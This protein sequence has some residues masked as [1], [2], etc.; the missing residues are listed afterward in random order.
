MNRGWDSVVCI[1]IVYP[2]LFDHA[3]SGE[4][5]ILETMSKILNDPFFT[6]IEV[7]WIKDDQV[8][9]NVRD[10]LKLS[11]ME[12]LYN[13]APPIRGMDVN[14]CS[15]DDGQRNQSVANF[16]KVIDE[17]YF[18]GAK[19]LHCVSGKDPGVDKRAEAKRNLIDSLQKLC[20]YAQEKATDYTLVVSLENS[21]RE[22][23]RRA[24]LGPTD[25]TVELAREVYQGSQ[26]FGVL[27]DEGHFPLMQEDPKKSLEMA[28]DLLT[29][30]H[31]GNCYSKD[32]SKP[33]FGDKH[34]PFGVPDSD[35]D[36]EEMGSFLGTLRAI[37][38]FQKRCAT[39][40]PVLSFEIGPWGNISPE[41]V[42][43][44][45]KRTFS[46][47]WAISEGVHE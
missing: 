8:R 12:I 19:I 24:L 44:T 6:A 38:Y 36:A 42:V 32:S 11:G 13:G 22:V 20:K 4:G 1:G 23:D 35:V 31:I 43:A 15:C 34:L 28:K 2:K 26:N 16:K 9:K 39:R 10:L 30:I 7:T 46:R 40:L 17:A 14:L 25:E 3:N 37:G 5:P 33:Y 29:H 47:S 41:L 21:D 18:L 45:L 27:L